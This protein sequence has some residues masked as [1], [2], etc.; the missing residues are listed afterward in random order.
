MSENPVHVPKWDMADRMRKSLRDA[1]IGVQ[2]M[3]DYLE[4]SRNTVGN[5]IN[6]HTPPPGPVLRLWAMRCGVPYEWLRLGG[7]PLDSPRGGGATPGITAGILRILAPKTVV[8][9]RRSAL[10]AMSLAA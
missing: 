3:A 7:D 10:P 8:P 4:I 5:Y 9:Q 1:G 6:G 2:D